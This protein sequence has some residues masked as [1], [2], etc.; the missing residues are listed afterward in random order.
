MYRN[1]GDTLELDRKDKTFTTSIPPSVP[2]PRLIGSKRLTLAILLFFAC[3]ISYSH[4]T[5]LSLG[6]V[7]MVNHTAIEIN[8]QLHQS[9][10]N[11]TFTPKKISSSCGGI[12]IVKEKASDG[13]F[14]WD[15]LQQGSALGSFFYGYLCSQIIGGM[16]AQRFG[17]KIVIGVAVLVSSFLTIFTPSTAQISLTALIIVRAVLGF[18]QGVIMP[19]IHTLWSFWA[20]EKERSILVGITFAGLQVGN[21][22]SI[23]ISSVLCESSLGWPSIFYLFGLLGFLWCGLWFWLAASNPNDSKGMKS[24]EKNYLLEHIR[25]AMGKSGKPPA[26]PWKKALLSPPVWAI[27][28]GH[29]AADFGSYLMM[30][31]MPTLMNELFS[32]PR[33]YLGIISALPFLAFFVVIQFGGFLVDNIINK[34]LLSLVNARRLFMVIALVLQGGLLV[35]A[36]YL[37]C[38]Q[39]IPAI[40][41][42][43]I[44]VGISG[45]QFSSFVVSYLDVAP[46]FA[47][48]L[49]GVGNTI[50]SFS[51]I[52]GPA[53]MGIMTPSGSREEWQS[54]F[55]VT[56]GILA[57]GAVIYSIF[58]KGEV[59]GWAKSGGKD[60]I[61]EAPQEGDV[62]L[63]DLKKQKV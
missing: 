56:F 41:L 1:M 7:C 25:N 22:V 38:A 39:T 20:P 34:K 3:A 63:E 16:L 4:R 49:L 62:L 36:G 51:G 29:F 42:I 59:Q 5:D 6:I 18:S 13:P 52:L 2:V 30:G 28:F 8:N 12:T 48:A 24:D 17:G 32:L 31:V 46:A 33:E 19:T 15:K 47:G 55:W 60:T 45:F 44:A 50:S 11:E 14:V 40:I 21:L 9:S 43:T 54:F 23:S 27:Y 53:L 58:I 61:L 10:L 35:V 26:M 37:D 57:T